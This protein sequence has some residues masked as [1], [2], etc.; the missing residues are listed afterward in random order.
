MSAFETPGTFDL[1][2]CLVSTFKYLLTE[3]AARAHLR[4][5][6]RALRP[7]GVYAL[8]FHLSPVRRPAQ[9]PRAVDGRAQRGDR[10]LQGHHLAS[11]PP[12]RAARRSRRACASG[13]KGRS[14]ARAPSGSSEPMTRGRCATSCAGVPRARARGHVR[15]PLRGGRAPRA[16]GRNSSTPCSC[17]GAAPDSTRAAGS[18]R[19][20][21]EGLPSN[22]SACGRPET[23]RD[24][25]PDRHR[26]RRAPWPLPGRG[27]RPVD[28]A[29]PGMA[30][31]VRRARLCGESQRPG[32]GGSVARW[33]G[34]SVALGLWGSGARWLWGSGWFPGS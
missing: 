23:A 22:T 15:L 8:G 30:G 18:P 32:L 17:S 2:H 27:S 1:A 29:R 11:G 25:P 12:R 28:S 13:G 7:G 33:L 19:S 26:A 10:R 16:V 14:A 9:G 24:V 20:E 6:A 5:V 4:S 3:A 34:G 21:A 31:P